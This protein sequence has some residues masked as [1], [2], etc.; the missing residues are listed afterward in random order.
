MYLT[1]GAFHLSPALPASLLVVAFE[2]LANFAWSVGQGLSCV[3]SLAVCR[4]QAFSPECWAADVSSSCV[5]GK[6]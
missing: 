1:L 4:L 6:L 5:C 3:C 2:R